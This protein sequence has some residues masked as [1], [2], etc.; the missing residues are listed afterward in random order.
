MKQ[1]YDLLTCSGRINN[2][3]NFTKKDK[4]KTNNLILILFMF[5]GFSNAFG[6][7]DLTTT[8]DGTWTCPAGIFTIKVEVIGG[9]GGVSAPASNDSR[10]G[11]GGGAYSQRTT[12]NVTPG[13]I[14]NF[15]IG[16]GGDTSGSSGG[17]TYFGNTA[18]G[19][20]TGAVALAKGGTGNTG[21]AAVAGGASASG[22][23]DI[24]TSGGAGAAR[25]NTGSG[26][27]GGGAGGISTNGGA[28]LN[29]TGG[30]PGTGYPF[31]APNTGYGGNSRNTA[32]SGTAGFNYGGGAGASVRSGGSG[33]NGV[34]G[35]Q[36][37]IR[38]TPIYGTPTVTSFTPTS[39]CIGTSVTI[40]GTNFSGASIVSFNG[41]N[42]IFTINTITQITATVPAGATTGTIAV[43]TPGGTGTSAGSFTIT[44][45]P[46]AIGGGAATVCVG[47]NTPAFTNAVGGGTWSITNGSGSASITVGGVVTGISAGNATVVYT[48][49][50]C[51][52]S[53]PIT[54]NNVPAITTNPSN[55]SI[56]AGTNTSFSVV[57]SNTPTSYVWEVSIDGGSTWSTVTNGGV[58][59]GATTAT[60]SL[61]AVPASMDSYRYRARATNSCGSSA[62]ST[63]AILSVTLSYCTPSFTSAVE[64][65]SNVTFNTINNSSANVCG[66]GTSYENFTAV[67]TNAF[68]G[69][70]YTLSVTA[71]TCGNWTDYIYAYFDWNRDG[72]FVDAG[73]SYNLG[74]INNTTAGVLTQ[75]ITIPAGASLGSTRM[76]IIK[77]FA[78]APTDPCRTG[79]GFGQA[80]DYTINIIN[81]PVCAAPTA[82]PTVFSPIA[83]GTSITGSFTAASPAPDSYLV[84]ISTF[85]TAPSAPVN[86]TSYAIGSSLSSG[87]IVVDNDTNTTFTA[88][89]LNNNTTYYFYIYSFNGICTGGPLYLTT[90]PLT[91]NATTTAVLPSYCTPS[92]TNSSAYISSIR[93]VGTISDVTN[94][95]TTYSAG[96]YGNYSGTTI[97]TQV[98]GS[99]INL[100]II[101]SGTYTNPP[102][103]STSQFIKTWVDWNKDGDFDDSGEQV[104]IS[105]TD[106][107]PVATALDNIYGFVVPAGTFPGN[108]R[109][110]VR[111]RAY[112][113]SA[114]LLPCGTA[115]TTGET[116]DY[117][118]RIVEDC[119]SK[120][121]SVTNGS[122]CGPTNTVTLNAT[123]TAT[124][125]GFRWYTTAS[126]GAPI[127]TT[128][129]GSWTTPSISTTTTYYV[130]AYD[131]VCETIH[132]TPVIAT[133]LPTSNITVT[134]SVP[135]VCGEGNVVQISATGDFVTETLLLQDFEAGMSPFTVT[136]PVSTNAGADTP[137]S[138]KTSPY[139]P[140]ST[141][142]WR[143][144]VNSGAVGTTGNRFAFTTSDYN[145]SNIE[146][147][148]TSPSIDASL[149]TSLTLTYN[150]IY[151][152]F[153]G[154]SGRLEVSVN[155]G[156]WS[157][158]VITYTTDTGTPSAF[159]SQ[160]VN[161]TPYAGVTDLRFRFRYIAQWDDGWAIDNI[162]LEG[163]KPLNTTFTWTGGSVNAFID[164]ALTIPY[165]AQ[166]VTTVY[167]VPTA[168]Q[169][170]APSWSFTAN[171]TLG[172]G[173]PVSQLVT[174]NNKTKLWK[175]T[176]DN[177]WYNPNNWEPVG[178]P[179]ANTCVFVYDGPFDSRINN[180]SNNAYAKTLTVRPN[181]DLQILPNNTLTVT[182]A[183][184]V[185]N[186]GLFNLENASS[187]IQI[188]N[189]ANSGNINMKRN[190]NIRRLDYVYWSSPVANFALPNVSPATTGYKW[191]WTPTIPTNLNGFG[192]WA[193]TTE[194]MTLGKG[195]IVRGP[196]A[197]TTAFQN[198]T[199][200]FTGVPNNGTIT[201]PISRGT[202][203]GANYA[204][205]VSPTPATKDDDNWNLIGNP[206]PSA[207]HADNFLA[208]NTNIA[209]FIKLWTHGTLPSNAIADPFYQNFVLNYTVADYITYNYLG[210][211][212][213]VFD[214]RIAAGQGF[215]VLMNH[216][217]AAATENV[218]FA[219]TLRSN[220]YRNDQFFRN[221]TE[222]AGVEKNRIW[223]DLIAPNNSASR[224]LLG[225]ASGATNGFDRLYDAPALDVKAN[226]EIYSLI[227]TEKF[228]IQGKAVPFDSNDIIPLG[229]KT[230]QAGNYTIAI[231]K[232]DGLFTDNTNLN[233]YLEDRLLNIIHNLKAAP[234]TFTA[235]M[236]IFD[237]R[238]V[239]RYTESTLSTDD[240]T[241]LENSVFV[242]TNDMLNVKS[243][244]ELLKEVAVYDIQGK[245]LYD[246]KNI[247]SNIL[248]ISQLN[249]KTAALLVK[250]TLTNGITLTKKVIF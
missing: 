229:F 166:S 25:V 158:P 93:S 130:T 246:N 214:G 187:L 79:A 23:G 6:Q 67:S 172:N 7:T 182:D 185:D 220:T 33:N 96:G 114:T 12:M 216:T 104:Y 217:S 37:V 30:A 101:V 58:Y 85:N 52:S 129:S 173:C 244:S 2:Q 151:G 136:T 223:L 40:T 100:E 156:A 43:T 228:N 194:S 209:G 161:F 108:Y 110:R 134:P 152:A 231:A 219:N 116:E 175:G 47:A 8:G 87:Y 211:L 224:T 122:A 127:A 213:P 64:P 137:W 5:F 16:S 245:L 225:Y 61:T 147:I 135:E 56:T 115:Y 38:I 163:V 27:G 65:I 189:V 154:D 45:T 102:C 230:P 86:G 199:A 60:L 202:Y 177:N 3:S 107:A 203:D 119:P 88:T 73:E 84:V 165:V 15:T 39:G 44:P 237:N 66:A 124:A 242:Y 200:T 34:A 218:T 239:I 46:A 167:V 233:I 78:S 113:D 54:I 176:V 247:Q 103:S 207:I 121:T 157:A 80:E 198:Y 68:R 143:P 92:S 83:G 75:S 170:A 181:G 123:K 155:G 235:E 191:K 178:V 20:P 95:P 19:N 69:F 169:L 29:N 133:I 148:M 62:N 98:A 238:F 94:G 234:Y 31:I 146:T 250:I 74:T 183:V 193:Y 150:H 10:G 197:Y 63:V 184:T 49:G 249:P 128:A 221:E 72:D 126:G 22:T 179:D 243:N 142:V 153:S 241:N 70:S 145:N 53:T 71:N 13:N 180:T 17:D 117:T 240:I 36:G 215:F 232:T 106:A 89:G 120:I 205:G 174:I 159:A 57:A 112:C 168:V 171:A 226:F 227:G 55:A 138:V 149:Y 236:G 4:T 192:N 77:N 91:G 32:G 190:V 111:T 186:N 125:T 196:D 144:A 195:Y 99:G 105:G 140:N 118:I 1:I 204:T 21:I 97:A 164:P 35:A 50:T 76:R 82:Q 41:T 14:Y 24:R 131:G 201:I 210:S 188:N 206:Y 28:G 26:G 51:S 81:A 11:G 59:S 9:G 162:K 208:N 160:T 248:S 90:S 132:R 18:A 42:A 109:M 212:S 141:S 48:I 222:E 139:V